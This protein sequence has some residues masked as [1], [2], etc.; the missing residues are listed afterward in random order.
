MAI[1]T[2]IM[3]SGVSG[4]VPVVNQNTGV[5]LQ[6]VNDYAVIF[7]SNNAPTPGPDTQGTIVLSPALSGGYGA[8]GVVAFE[9]AL[10]PASYLANNWLPVQGWIPFGGTSALTGNTYT[11]AANQTLNL[12]VPQVQGFYAL[13]VRLVTLPASGIIVASGTTFPAS[14][15]FSPAELAAIAN[16]TFL[17]TANVLAQCD[18]TNQDYFQLAQN[19]TYP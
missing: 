18:Q 13:R 2:S 17:S 11:L 6:Q 5:L 8:G 14:N 9:E 19:F 12:T 10:T 16:L 3:N 7:P 4:G 1:Q 15:V